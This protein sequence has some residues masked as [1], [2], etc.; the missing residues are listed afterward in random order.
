V[1]DMLI[2]ITLLPLV[3]ITPGLAWTF[4]ILPANRVPWPE[5]LGWSIGL[6]IIVAPLSV[7]W[8]NLGLG[9][10]VTQWGIALVLLA[11]TSLPVALSLA[12]G[13]LMSSFRERLRHDSRRS[14]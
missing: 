10:P 7:F 3:L 9:V 1:I 6:S 14:R 12:K 2:G 8:A 13:R 11:V 5:R 4:V